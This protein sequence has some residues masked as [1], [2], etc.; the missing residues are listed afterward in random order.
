MNTLD[1]KVGIYNAKTLSKTPSFNPKIPGGG[2][3][4]SIHWF[5]DCVPFWNGS[6]FLTFRFPELFD[7]TFLEVKA[8]IQL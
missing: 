7:Q 1:A 5:G 4:D 8:L 2:I 3:A 6:S